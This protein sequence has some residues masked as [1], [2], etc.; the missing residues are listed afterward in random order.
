MAPGF[1]DGF[2]PT[3]PYHWLTPPTRFASGNQPPSSGEITL[4]PIAG[5]GFPTAGATTQDAQAQLILA[6]GTF[7][8]G[9]TKVTV[10][11]TPVAGHPP[12]SGFQPL[13]NVYL[14]TTSAPLA[15]PATVS[16]RFP[17]DLPAASGVWFA[18]EDGSTWTK[19][20]VATPAPYFATGTV[21]EGGYFVAGLES[22]GGH[23][24]ANQRDLSSSGSA[25]PLI[26]GVAVV[27][28]LVAGLPL[29]LVNRGRGRCR[30]PA[31][32][33]GKRN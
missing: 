14:I 27:V 2:S 3:T 22:G 1:Y 4:K 17:P 19:L 21:R 20:S 18:P 16:L 32:K 10:D 15:K 9:P 12:I 5:D 29:L 28:V 7:A 24:G 8:P 30:K 11:L 31:G 33:P 23:G 26:A 13:G 25:L 6:T